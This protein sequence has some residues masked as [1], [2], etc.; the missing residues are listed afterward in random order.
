MT[1]RE[2]KVALHNLLKGARYIINEKIPAGSLSEQCLGVLSNFEKFKITSPVWYLHSAIEV[3]ANELLKVNHELTQYIKE[4]RK[5]IDASLKSEEKLPLKVRVSFDLCLP[6][7]VPENGE[8]LDA[9]YTG[10]I[11]WRKAYIIQQLFDAFINYATVKHH[12]DAIDYLSKIAED[13]EQM[14]RQIYL[15][16]KNWAKILG[17]A[18]KTMNVQI[19]EPR[20]T[21]KEKR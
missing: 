18:E 4:E 5:Q 17:A 16:H 12:T 8:D 21:K 19:L 2:R 7:V 6:V 3:L 13:N 1:K 9:I 10:D 15:Y 11:T 14:F 20:K